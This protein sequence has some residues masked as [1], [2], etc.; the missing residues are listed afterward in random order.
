MNQPLVYVEVQTCTVNRILSAETQ[1]LNFRQVA[2]GKV[3]VQRLRIRNLLNGDMP[4]VELSMVPLN[5]SGAYSI[6]NTLRPLPPGGSHDMIV[7][8]QPRAQQKYM[9]TLTVEC[10]LGRVAVVL[11]GEGVSPTLEVDPPEKRLDMG[12]VISGGVTTKEFTLRNT[13][14]FP[15]HYNIVTLSKRH[16]NYDSCH[17]YDCVPSEAIIPANTEQKVKVTFAPDHEQPVPYDC[18]IKIDV[19][20]QGQD[21]ILSMK[22]WCWERQMYVVAHAANPEP[23]EGDVQAEPEY[24]K[25]LFALPVLL[26]AKHD[27]YHLIKAP[28]QM[29]RLVLQFPRPREEDVPPSE[30]DQALADTKAAE[31][32]AK[33]AAGEVTDDFVSAARAEIAALRAPQKRLVTSSM[34]IVLGCCEATK[35]KSGSGGGY[36]LIL[37][38]AAQVEG[39]MSGSLF[40]PD[41][42]KGEIQAGNSTTVTFTFTPPQADESEEAATLKVG[43]WLEQTYICRLTGGYVSSCSPFVPGRTQAGSC[44]VLLWRLAVA[45]E[46]CHRR[47]SGALLPLS[48]RLCRYYP[49]TSS[50][51][52][53]V[54]LVLRAFAIL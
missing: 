19:P 6:L 31:L 22:G 10:S 42:K 7:Q 47:L 32:E 15:L 25:D 52:Q 35:G 40:K 50:A 28:E 43:Q 53:D 4:P 3:V 8:F 21:H 11:I 13:S 23:E 5:P 14:V 39:D 17:V 9:D 16:S 38:K 2:V 12:H 33:I 36:E 41:K 51:E 54:M 45:A 34:Q 29:R 37:D 24:L 48:C 30:Q 26:D 20:N 44:V 46:S 49:A 18:L 27:M 1:R